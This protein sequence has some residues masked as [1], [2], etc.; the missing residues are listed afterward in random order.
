M[1]LMTAAQLQGNTVIWGGHNSTIPG[2]LFRD[3]KN[4]SSGF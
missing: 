1:W 2:E 3:E 4:G